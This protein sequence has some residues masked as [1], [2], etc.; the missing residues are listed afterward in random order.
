MFLFSQAQQIASFRLQSMVTPKHT[1]GHGSHV[2]LLTIESRLQLF[3]IDGV[4][5]VTFED[6]RSSITSL[7][8]V[9]VAPPA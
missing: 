7:W 2:V 5:L 3:T 8:V 4:H 1:Q 9:S 6:H